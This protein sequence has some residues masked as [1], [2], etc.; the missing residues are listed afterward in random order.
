MT[1]AQLTF[2]LSN[3][4]NALHMQGVCVRACYAVGRRQAERILPL[5]L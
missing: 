4:S 2:P 3:A 1:I 5:V